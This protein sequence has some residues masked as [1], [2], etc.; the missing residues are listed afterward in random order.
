MKDK[1]FYN[2]LVTST[3]H[4]SL[5]TVSLIFNTILALTTMAI[6]YLLNY[7]GYIKNF[8]L[9]LTM[10]VLILPLSYI[11]ITTIYTVSLWYEK[12]LQIRFSHY[13][14]H[15]E[16]GISEKIFAT[17]LHLFF[18]FIMGNCLFFY[19]MARTDNLDKFYSYNDFYIFA[20]VTIIVITNNIYSR[21]I[22]RL[23]QAYLYFFEYRRYPFL[24]DIAKIIKNVNTNEAAVNLFILRLE[25]SSPQ[26]EQRERLKAFEVDELLDELYG[27]GEGIISLFPIKKSEGKVALCLNLA[28]RAF[29]K[30]YFRKLEE[31]INKDILEPD[32]SFTYHINYK[33]IKINTDASSRKLKLAL[34]KK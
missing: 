18:S 25:K 10:T 5:V 34:L 28:S 15:G 16:E 30:E 11:A 8:S 1:Y 2:E 24:E 31:I 9:S 27:R 29:Y 21:L 23:L 13:F 7:E 26:A 20:Y 14:S 6:Y 17:P 22:P 3:S 4:S 33:S 12:R 19:V 32:S